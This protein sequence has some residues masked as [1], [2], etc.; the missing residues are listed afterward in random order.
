[1]DTTNGALRE[2][3]TSTD[4]I[5]AEVDRQYGAASVDLTINHALTH[6][7]LGERPTGR[8][9]HRTWPTTDQE[10]ITE[11]ERRLNAD[12]LSPHHR[13]TARKALTTIGELG[14]RILSNR[15]EASLHRQFE[16]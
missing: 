13:R 3:A 10:V 11:L 6:S 2:L 14:E 5:L 9:C 7:L 8:G 1:M 12:E 16:Q 4:T 15:A